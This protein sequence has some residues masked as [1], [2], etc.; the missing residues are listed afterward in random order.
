VG[1]SSCSENEADIVDVAIFMFVSWVLKCDLRGVGESPPYIEAV[2]SREDNGGVMGV[3]GIVSST[4]IDGIS[5]EI[6]QLGESNCLEAREG[7]KPTHPAL[8][9]SQPSSSQGASRTSVGRLGTSTTTSLYP[10]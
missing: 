10:D 4:M 8:G 3:S 1:E 5:G 7:T 2:I 6:R 9:T